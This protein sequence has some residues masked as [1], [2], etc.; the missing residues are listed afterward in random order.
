MDLDDFETSFRL[1]AGVEDDSDNEHT[2]P[3]EEPSHDAENTE[4]HESSETAAAT[5]DGTDGDGDTGAAQAQRHITHEPAN[6]GDRHPEPPDLAGSLFDAVTDPPGH[7][8]HHHPADPGQP[9]AP[10]P[11]PSSERW[12]E[13]DYDLLVRVLGDIHVEGAE[14]LTGKQ[15]SVVAYIALHG[16]VSSERL[17]TAVW[18]GDGSHTKA[19]MNTLGR[20]R[21]EIGEHHLPA[22]ADSRYRPGPA[23]LTD[24]QLFEAH[25]DALPNAKPPPT[26]PT[27]CDPRSTS[28]PDPS[29]PTPPTKDAH[30][31]P[32][33]MSRTGS[34]AGNSRSA[35]AG[36]AAAPSFLLELERPAEAVAVAERPPSR[37]C[38]PTRRSP[39]SSCEPDAVAGDRNSLIRVFEAHIGA[40]ENLD[41][42]DAEFVG[43]LEG[44]L[45]ACRAQPGVTSRFPTDDSP[46]P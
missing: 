35:S 29:S 17:E 6:E 41:L 10:E 20:I 36:A 18:A 1:L 34:A 4:E 23:L 12:A 27:R 43:A 46:V 24:T 15:I 26:P 39:R 14:G 5:S 19:R 40:L 30:R 9:P 42:H 22:A 28:S 31:S 37:S 11:E 38:Q 2:D 32:G 25:V 45:S 44:W 16:E 13:P 3:D 33:S 8:G 7:N 21:T